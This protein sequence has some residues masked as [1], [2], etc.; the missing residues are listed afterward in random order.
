MA[1]EATTPNRK[2]SLSTRTRE[3]VRNLFKEFKK[4]QRTIHVQSLNAMPA[5]ER[6]SR[7]LQAS[8]AMYRA[9]KD[10]NFKP[11][12]EQIKDFA[13]A[14]EIIAE[15][16]G[17]ATQKDGSYSK[18]ALNNEL[19]PMALMQV[20][21]AQTL[22]DSG[23]NDASRQQIMEDLKTGYNVKRSEIAGYT[24]PDGTIISADEYEKNQL[25]QEVL[26]VQQ[27]PPSYADIMS[28]DDILAMTNE[29]ERN[30][31]IAGMSPL[32]QDRLNKKLED[33]KKAE[34]KAFEE[35]AGE[36]RRR[37]DDPDWAKDDDNDNFK[38]E[39]GDI[40]EYLMKDIILASAAWAANKAAGLGGIVL[41]ET[42]SG[43]YKHAIHP[44]GQ[45]T[46]KII[47]DQWNNLKKALFGKK[48]NE[49]T[50]AMEIFD[51]V[52]KRHDS[53]V[54]ESKKRQIKS[55]EETK[56]LTE[57]IDY[58]RNINSNFV[59]FGDDD[60]KIYKQSKTG[61]K[62]ES[63]KE[64]KP[65]VPEELKESW[66]MYRDANRKEQLE[67][68]KKKFPNENIETWFDQQIKFE[69]DYVRT[70]GK[71]TIEEPRRL[72]PDDKYFNAL[73]EIRADQNMRLDIIKEI[74]AFDHQM[75]LFAAYYS[76]YKYIELYRQNPENK[77]LSNREEVD[78]FLKN[79]HLEARQIFL[80]AEKQRRMGNLNISSRETLIDE[81]EQMMKTS[82]NLA[83]NNDKT[84]V[85]DK[86]RSILGEEDISED[87]VKTLLSEYKNSDPTERYAAER[88]N[89]DALER[90]GRLS[91]KG[92]TE[93]RKSFDEAAEMCNKTLNK[94]KSDSEKIDIKKTYEIRKQSQGRH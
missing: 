92:I 37:R 89:C 12:P 28:D 58:L 44:A 64:I 85:R 54:E 41:Y 38:I 94:G 4:D 81:A 17:I 63:F 88:F 57:C 46:G 40:I 68:L 32:D 19:S 87:N 45:Y 93:K 90:E 75:E 67:T 7:L 80:T 5:A 59:V 10:R 43:I 48:E 3:G 24:Q 18:E 6:N 60:D 86:F 74:N 83:E 71:P 26:E 29:E 76:T 39:Q 77:T 91:E 72:D 13:A 50:E 56:K 15:K 42:A 65:S 51:D 61:W 55:E 11:S 69:E 36:A 33:K 9:T 8:T 1:K 31:I 47:S 34:D 21:A 62:E 53:I 84:P 20:Y 79:A 27:V 16:R 70:Q 2:G 52:I 25:P 30:Q 14:C 22:K 49:N 35:N 73:T 78:T 82:C 23:E 66:K